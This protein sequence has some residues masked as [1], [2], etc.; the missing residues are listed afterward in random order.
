MTPAIRLVFRSIVAGLTVFLTQLQQSTTWDKSLLE[1]AI[2]AGVLA[3]LEYGTPLNAVV[4]PGK[5]A[6]IVPEVQG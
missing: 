6:K 2:T 3:G 1:A 4:G 5:D